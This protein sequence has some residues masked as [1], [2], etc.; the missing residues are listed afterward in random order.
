MR[1]YA[2]GLLPWA[3]IL[4]VAA[5]AGAQHQG[6]EQPAPNPPQQ[7]PTTA[8]TPAP[9]GQDDHSAHGAP[10]PSAGHA[11]KEAIPAPTDADRAAAFPQAMQGHGVHDQE[12]HY[13]V[14]FDQLEWE[15]GDNGGPGWDNTTWIGGDLN[16]LWLR[17]EGESHGGRVESAFLDALWGRRVSRWWDVVGGARQDFRPGPGQTWVGGGVQGLAPYFFELQATGYVGAHGRTLFRIEADYELL[18]TNRLIVEPTVEAEFH[19]KADPERGVGSGLSTLEG[20]LRLRYE[21]KREFAPYIG[22]TWTRSFFGTA[23]LARAASEDVG[24][25]RLAVGV[26]TWF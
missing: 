2:L 16:R 25:A 9:A 21:I 11:P 3:L 20:G 19:G 22:V 24:S 6:H 26:R 10:K 5:S 8:G 12:L 23:D 4:A 14:L 1:P 13:Q 15:G 18:L 17:S 7:A